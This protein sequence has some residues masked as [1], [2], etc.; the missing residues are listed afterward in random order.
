MSD[1]LADPFEALDVMLHHEQDPP[2]P[3]NRVKVFRKLLH[4]RVWAKL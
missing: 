2:S 3:Q 1:A 4:F